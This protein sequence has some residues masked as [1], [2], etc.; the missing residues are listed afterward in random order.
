MSF[1]E[2]VGERCGQFNALRRLE[3]ELGVEH[4]D[5]LVCAHGQFVAVM[6]AA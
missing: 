2:D 3:D 6:L 5:V 4:H 1:V